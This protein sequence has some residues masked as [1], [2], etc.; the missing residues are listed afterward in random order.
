ME[1]KQQRNKNKPGMKGVDV[2][3][4]RRTVFKALFGSRFMT[5]LMTA[6]QFL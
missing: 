5:E 1:K 6:I 4:A 3:N 2:F